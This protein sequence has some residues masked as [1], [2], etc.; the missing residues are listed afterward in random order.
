MVMDS[1]TGEVLA[2]ADH[3]TFDA[4]EPLASDEADRGTRAMSDVFEPGRCRRC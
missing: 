2:L 4:N 3:P 1:R